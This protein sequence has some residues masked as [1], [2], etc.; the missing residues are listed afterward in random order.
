[1]TESIV[2]FLFS[3]GFLSWQ[4]QLALDFSH[5]KVIDHNIV[6]RVI[7]FI[8]DSNEFKFIMHWLPIVKDVHSFEYIN[9]AAFTALQ[10]GSHQVT[11]FKN[12]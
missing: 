8:F 12:N 11:N 10:L 4:L 5:E 9:E 3:L 1:M 7:K 6:G 2:I